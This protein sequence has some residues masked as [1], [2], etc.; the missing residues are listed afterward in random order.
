MALNNT[1]DA[2]NVHVEPDRWREESMAVWDTYGIELQSE[3]N[4]RP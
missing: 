3:S 2:L 4:W 1:V